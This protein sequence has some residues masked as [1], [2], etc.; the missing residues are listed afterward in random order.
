MPESL[1]DKVAQINIKDSYGHTPLKIA[2]LGKRTKMTKLL[3]E[4]GAME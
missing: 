4:H 3:R 2:E 1:I